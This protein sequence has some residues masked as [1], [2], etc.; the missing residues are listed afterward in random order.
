MPCS[1]PELDGDS[2]LSSFSAWAF[3][4]GRL[5][6]VSHFERGLVLRWSG[7][8]HRAQGRGKGRGVPAPGHSAPTF[9]GLHLSHIQALLIL[10][11][12]AR[13]GGLALGR[14][15][16]RRCNRKA[17]VSFWFKKC[18][19]SFRSRITYSAE[20]AKQCSERPSAF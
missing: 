3:H 16:F 2:G 7:G 20:S 13:V 4:G 17:H 1:F 19:Y 11:L 8:G 5:S 15:C 12:P 14:E 6:R 18:I 9:L 10:E